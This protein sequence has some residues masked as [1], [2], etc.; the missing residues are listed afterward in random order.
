MASL[1]FPVLLVAFAA[2][3]TPLVANALLVLTG[4]TMI[5]FN[6]L[7]NGVLQLLVAEQYRG[8]LMAL[9]SLLYIG[10]S[11]A[12]G[13]PLL[14]AAARAWGVEWAVGGSAVATLLYALWT[15]RSSVLKEL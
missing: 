5:M 14:G 9:Y 3:R 8:R 13:A 4:V 11:S 1:G 7:G 10:L 2:S 12:V 6:S 15:A